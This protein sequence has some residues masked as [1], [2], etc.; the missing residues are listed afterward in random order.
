ME[1][2]GRRV[3]VLAID[4][5]SVACVLV[6]IIVEVLVSIL[7]PLHHDCSPIDSCVP[8]RAK[9]FC[10]PANRFFHKTSH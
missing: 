10:P 7:I 8:A 9:R 3:A 6:A 2:R 4:V 5:V 1:T